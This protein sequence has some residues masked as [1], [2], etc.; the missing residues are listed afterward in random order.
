MFGELAENKKKD[1]KPEN[2]QKKIL[3]LFFYLP[4]IFLLNL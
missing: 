4:Q 2:R 1:P 3:R